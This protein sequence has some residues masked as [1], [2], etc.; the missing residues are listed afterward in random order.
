[1]RIEV[2]EPALGGRKERAAQIDGLAGSPWHHRSAPRCGSLNRVVIG[3]SAAGF[4]PRSSQSRLDFGS[5]QRSTVRAVNIVDRAIALLTHRF[6]CPRED[7]N[8]R[9]SI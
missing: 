2:A 5:N 6:K 9:H 4:F 8:L 1:M 7:S 3:C